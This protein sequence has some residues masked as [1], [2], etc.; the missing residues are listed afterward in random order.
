MPHRQTSDQAIVRRKPNATDRRPDA[1]RRGIHVESQ[2]DL[3]ASGRADQS[4]LEPRK[5]PHEALAAELTN[6]LV[7]GVI[8][9]RCHDARV[10]GSWLSPREMRRYVMRS[11]S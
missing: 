3:G 11:F 4:G 5:M 10:A 2:R 1:A 8:L 9:I 7:A 6:H